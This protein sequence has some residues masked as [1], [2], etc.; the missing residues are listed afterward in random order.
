MKRLGIVAKSEPAA[1]ATNEHYY[2]IE[3]ALATP[4]GEPVLFVRVIVA[5]SPDP[6]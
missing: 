3:H 1:R 6:P 5:P 2:Q 4:T